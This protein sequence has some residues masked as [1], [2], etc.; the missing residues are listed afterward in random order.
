MIS[1]VTGLVS[2]TIQNYQQVSILLISGPNIIHLIREEKNIPRCIAELREWMHPKE[3][4]VHFYH[5]PDRSDL[6]V[7]VRSIEN[8]LERTTDPQ[9]RN[10]YELLQD[11]YTRILQYQKNPV[12]SGQVARSLSRILMTEAYLFSLGCGDTSHIRHVVRPLQTQQVRVHIRIIEA[13][14]GDAF[15]GN[16]GN[17]QE[18]PT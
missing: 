8:A 9:T 2:H 5:M 16:E 13:P 15:P 10:Y 18:I 1:E 7:Q 6:R 14:R 17:V 4:P 3:R 11:R 12:F